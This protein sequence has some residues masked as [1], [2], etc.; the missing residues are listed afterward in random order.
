MKARI[1]SERNGVVTVT[2]DESGILIQ[3]SRKSLDEACAFG[4]SEDSE[5]GLVCERRENLDSDGVW[6]YDRRGNGLR[7]FAMRVTF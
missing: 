7:S 6:I 5:R 4:Y 3:V 2:H 1:L